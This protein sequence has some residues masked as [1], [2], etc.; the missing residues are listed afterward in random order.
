MLVSKRNRKPIAVDRLGLWLSK[1]RNIDGRWVGTMESKPQPGLRRIEDALDLIK[2][3]DPLHYSRVVHNLERVWM[4]VLANALAC[5]DPS[6]K[7]CVLDKRFV[8]LETTTLQRIASTIVHEA[9]HAKLE[10]SGISYEG[11]LSN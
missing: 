11:A 4:H 10:R 1:G 2:R 9:T 7:A 5:Y 8:L 3:H 6:L